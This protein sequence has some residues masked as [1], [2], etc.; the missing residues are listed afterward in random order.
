MVN[1]KIATLV[2]ALSDLA[3]P[4]TFDHNEVLLPV[5]SKRF[6]FL[7]CQPYKSGYLIVL[8]NSNMKVLTV[9]SDEALN[10]NRLLWNLVCRDLLDNSFIPRLSG[11]YVGKRVKL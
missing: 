10:G 11:H 5:N 9:L 6:E 3:K 7:S 2:N 4:F 8:L 1:F